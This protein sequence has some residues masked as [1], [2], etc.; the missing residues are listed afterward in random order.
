LGKG[1]IVTKVSQEVIDKFK[2]KVNSIA[3]PLLDGNKILSERGY[4]LS[5]IK[6]INLEIW[7]KVKNIIP[8]A[9]LSAVESTA[10]EYIENIVTEILSGKK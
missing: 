3:G 10:L 4:S 5:E 7:A 1:Y 9:E 6:K 2:N 8:P